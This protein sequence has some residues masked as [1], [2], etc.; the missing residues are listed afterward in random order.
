MCT[1]ALVLPSLPA[2]LSPQR[3]DPHAKTEAQ[4]LLTEGSGVRYQS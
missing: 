4:A 3:A 1:T 2:Q